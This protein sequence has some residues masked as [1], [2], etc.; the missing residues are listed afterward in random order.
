MARGTQD[1]AADHA[2]TRCPACLFTK[3]SYSQIARTTPACLSSR[4]YTQPLYP[5]Q[6]CALFFL[7]KVTSAPAPWSTLVRGIWDSHL[8][9]VTSDI[10]FSLGDLS[11]ALWTEPWATLSSSPSCQ[12]GKLGHPGGSSKAEGKV[13]AGNLILIPF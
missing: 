13:Q 8:H 2:W 6:L 3:E 7:G 12:L 11:P 4:P 5:G 10:S 9:G 1:G